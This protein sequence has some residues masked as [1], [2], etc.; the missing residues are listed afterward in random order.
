MGRCDDDERGGRLARTQQTPGQT[1]Q[2]PQHGGTISIVWC[3]R[4]CSSC[5]LRG[6]LGWARVASID[7][8]EWHRSS[9]RAEPPAFSREGHTACIRTQK[10]MGTVKG[11]CN[12]PIMACSSLF[13]AFLDWCRRI[14]SCRKTRPSVSDFWLK[15]AAN[16]IF[17]MT[18]PKG[19][20]RPP[21]KLTATRA[22]QPQGK[23]GRLHFAF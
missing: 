17:D 16:R 14:V 2:H 23:T 20:Q 21:P 13:V 9:A 5:C 10:H 4:T 6:W 22:M 1:S 3:A 8:E 7:F 11:T 18:R 19:Q 15:T 12:N